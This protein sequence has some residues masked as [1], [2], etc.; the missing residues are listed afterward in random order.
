MY[1]F[2]PLIFI[3]Q[4]SMPFPTGSSVT[5]KIFFNFCFFGGKNNKILDSTSINLYFTNRMIKL[6]IIII[7]EE[8]LKIIDCQHK[9]YI[10]DLRLA[11]LNWFKPSS[12][13]FW[14]Y[15]F[16]GSL[17]FSFCLVF[18]MSLCA[19]VYM[20]FVVTCWERADLLALVFGV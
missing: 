3:I 20:G 10:N 16:C 4:I 8:I 2:Y 9:R 13:I 1:L 12:S 5:G 17:M 19:S 6:N 11:P 15:F 18:A 7:F 14:R